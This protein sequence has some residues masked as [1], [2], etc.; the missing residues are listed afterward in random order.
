L[1]TSMTAYDGTYVALAEGLP[2]VLFTSDGTLARAHGHRAQVE[3]L[4]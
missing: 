4:T 2:A 1:R 3:L